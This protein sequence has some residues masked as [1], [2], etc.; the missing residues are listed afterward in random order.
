MSTAESQELGTFVFSQPADAI[1]VAK[2]GGHSSRKDLCVHLY[3][4]TS[5]HLRYCFR[6][7]NSYLVR[8]HDSNVLPE[9]E[10]K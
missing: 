9:F 3:T 7:L 2:D 5:I 10:S 8:L 1:L 6:K 4:Y